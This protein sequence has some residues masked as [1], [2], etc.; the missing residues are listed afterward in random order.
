MAKATHKK[1]AEVITDAVSAAQDIKPAS[2]HSFKL[3]KKSFQ[4]ILPQ[5]II[6][7]IGKRTALE[8]CSDDTVYTELGGKTINEFLVSIGSGAVK[9]I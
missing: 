6:P 8:A 9:E 4:Y 5:F 1:P 2:G 7:G 3:E